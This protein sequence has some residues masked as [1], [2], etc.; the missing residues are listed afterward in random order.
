[1]QQYI[2]LNTLVCISLLCLV[3][4]QTDRPYNYTPVLIK[5]SI[6]KAIQSYENNSINNDD[7]LETA[8][9]QLLMSANNTKTA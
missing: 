8:H 9:H 6:D 2:S 3:F 7:D 1:M 5:I 4:S